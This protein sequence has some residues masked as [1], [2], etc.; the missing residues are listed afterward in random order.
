MKITV[1]GPSNT[2]ADD[3]IDKVITRD[4]FGGDN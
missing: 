4:V 1:V 2:A 3:V